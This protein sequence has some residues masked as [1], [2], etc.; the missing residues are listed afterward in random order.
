MD[1]HP[2]NDAIHR[3]GGTGPAAPV[4]DGPIF[5][6]PTIHFKINLKKNTYRNVETKQVIFLRTQHTLKRHFD[7][8]LIP[9]RLLWLLYSTLMSDRNG[10]EE[11]VL[12]VLFFHVALVALP[13]PQPR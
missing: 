3:A 4:L 1:S 2:E 10:S 11:G 7:G 12:G 5:Q 8:Y 9:L 13:D 6:A